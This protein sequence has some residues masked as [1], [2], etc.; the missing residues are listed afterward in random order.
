MN[1][2]ITEACNIIRSN[3]LR[4]KKIRKKIA[5]LEK[6]LQEAKEHGIT[7]KINMSNDKS[8]V[9]TKEEINY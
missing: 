3:F 4:G 1:D 2:E 7:V 6:V 8:I 5:E 9:Q